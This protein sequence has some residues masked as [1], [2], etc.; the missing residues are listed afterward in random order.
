MGVVA[1]VDHYIPI[2]KME[3]QEKADYLFCRRIQGLFDE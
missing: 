2:D 1:R 3:Q